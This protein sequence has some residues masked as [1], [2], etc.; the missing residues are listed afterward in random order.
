MKTRKTESHGGRRAGA[1]RKPLSADGAKTS[2]VYVRVTL[3]EKAEIE[4]R[5]A[6]ANM[7]VSAWVL[8]RLLED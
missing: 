5:A 3:A 7:S 8:K 4:R 1:G 6:S 2:Q